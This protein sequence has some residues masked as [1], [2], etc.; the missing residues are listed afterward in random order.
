MLFRGHCF[1]FTFSFP[2]QGVGSYPS[3]RRR[4]PSPTLSR[5]STPNHLFYPLTLRPGP[6]CSSEM[7]SFRKTPSPSAP[8]HT[9][10][11]SPALGLVLVPPP[12]SSPPSSSPSPLPPLPLPFLLPLPP[13][14]PLP[15]S[16]HGGKIKG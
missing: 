1:P 13:L 11:A 9:S 2:V 5:Y 6:S 15:P 4:Y 12:P 14:P 7:K 10:D 3:D 16:P 8:Q